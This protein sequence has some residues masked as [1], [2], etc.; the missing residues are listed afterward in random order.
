MNST[1]VRL[2]AAHMELSSCSSLIMLLA[3]SGGKA[4]K[5]YHRLRLKRGIHLSLPLYL[6]L[7]GGEVYYCSFRLIPDPFRKD[8]T[9]GF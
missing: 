2:P 3:I 1:S 7:S 6:P 9:T 4:W 5:I 8:L